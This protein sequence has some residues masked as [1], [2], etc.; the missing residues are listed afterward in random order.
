MEEHPMWRNIDSNMDGFIALCTVL[1]KVRTVRLAGCGLGARSTAELS[2][3]FSDATAALTE[4][5]VRRNHFDE[6]ALAT[7]RAAAPQTC[8]ILAD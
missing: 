5:D 3:I 6:A 1:G 7:L 2:K 8:V 4:L